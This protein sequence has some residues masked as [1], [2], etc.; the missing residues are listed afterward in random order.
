MVP[1]FSTI[2]PPVAAQRHHSLLVSSRLQTLRAWFAER[3]LPLSLLEKNSWDWILETEPES[4]FRNI[5]L[6][7]EQGDLHRLNLIFPIGDDLNEDELTQI[8]QLIIKKKCQKI[9]DESTNSTHLASVNRKQRE[10]LLGGG[11]FAVL[12][13]VYLAVYFNWEKKD[14]VALKANSLSASLLEG[15]TNEQIE[16]LSQQ[17]ARLRQE[18]QQIEISTEQ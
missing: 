11:I 14:N 15:L 2:S 17:A 6:L 13:C 10:I 18:G 4:F 7:I 12:L 5:D 8:A 9:Q 16:I 3:S 1:N